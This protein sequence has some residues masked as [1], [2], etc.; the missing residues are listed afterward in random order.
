MTYAALV[1]E[2]LLANQLI[3]TAGLAKLTWGN[4]SGYHAESGRVV[5]KPSGVPYGD[6][7]DD[8]LVVLDLQGRALSG[9]LRPSSDTPTHLEVYRAFPHVAGICHTHSVAATAFSQAGRE[10]PCYGTTHADHFY[11]AVPI[12]RILTE[13]EVNQDYEL[14]TGKAIVECFRSLGLDPLRVPAILQ[15]YHAPFTFGPTPLKSVENAIALEYCAEMALRSLQL[16]PNLEPLP[17]HLLDKHFLRKHGPG[18]YYGQPK[19]S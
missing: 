8:D 18:A 14:E 6:L 3:A 10:L 4:V 11:G 12:C 16:N 15:R 17:A 1:D 13:A 7:R 5:I 9:E 19:K 2:V